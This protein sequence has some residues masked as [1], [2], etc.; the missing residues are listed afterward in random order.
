MV[1]REGKDH[2]T[3]CYF[4]II[5]L[6]GINHKNKHYVQYPDVPEPSGNMEYSSDSEHNDMSVVAF[7]SEE[8]NQ[9]VP[10]TLAELNDLT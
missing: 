1:L 8:D 7:K 9:P 10:L 5:N 6:K 3:D 4:S 2:I